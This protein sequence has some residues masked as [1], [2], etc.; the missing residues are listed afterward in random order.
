MAIVLFSSTLI[1][2]LYRVFHWLQCLR[3]LWTFPYQHKPLL[4]HRTFCKCV[5]VVA[6]FRSLLLHRHCSRA[7]PAIPTRP[8]Q[9]LAPPLHTCVVTRH[10]VVPYAHCEFCLPSEHDRWLVFFT[11]KD[12]LHSP[13]QYRRTWPAMIYILDSLSPAISSSCPGTC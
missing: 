10:P 11:C 3:S 1:S 6:I 9:Q 5:C 7:S 13:L 8:T 12:A 4:A 2:F